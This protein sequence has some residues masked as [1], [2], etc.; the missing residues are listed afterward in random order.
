MTIEVKL[1]VAVSAYAAFT[2]IG[3]KE[4][5]P[6]GS[7][8]VGRL[9]S[10]LRTE[11]RE[12]EEQ[13]VKLLREHGGK[14]EEGSVVLRKPEREEDESDEAFSVRV[15]EHGN[16]MKA[17]DVAVKAIMEEMVKIDYDP[18]PLEMFETQEADPSDP[19]AKR[20]KSTIEPNDMS[21]VLDFVKE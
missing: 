15:V 20:V 1:S 8:R 17:L 16:N 6:K 19:K 18:I 10:K 4:L 14:D 21:L 9:I 5:T 12:W 13:Q 7:Y 3:K 2:R 11:A